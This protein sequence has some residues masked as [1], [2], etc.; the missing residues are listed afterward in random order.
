MLSCASWCSCYKFLCERADIND[1]AFLQPKD[2]CLKKKIE[3]NCSD[4]AWKE[5]L[6]AALKEKRDVELSNLDYATDGRSCEMLSMSHEVPF[7]FDARQRLGF[8][9][10]RKRSY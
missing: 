2:P 5:L 1:F 10:W 9:T 3:L 4:V 7:N 8:F 6:K